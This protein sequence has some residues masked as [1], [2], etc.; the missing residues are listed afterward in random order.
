[1]AGLSF[2]LMGRYVFFIGNLFPDSIP[3]SA[4]RLEWRRSWLGVALYGAAGL[5]A[6]ISVYAALAIVALLPLLFFIPNLLEERE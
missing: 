4:R 2:T 3:M 6:F 5:L 1:M